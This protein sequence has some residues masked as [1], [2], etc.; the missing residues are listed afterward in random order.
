MIKSPV[1]WLLLT[2][3]AIAI[4]TA[5]GPAEATLGTNA[6]VV[7]L[8]GVWVWAALI[9]II[10][11][12]LI[13]L[14]GLITRREKLHYW[15]RALGRTGLIF[16]ITYLP[17]SLWAMQT[18]WNGLFLLEPRW[19]MAIVFAIGGLFLQIGIIL[20]KNPIWAS[21]SNF[22]YMLILWLAIQ[23]TEQVMHPP[24][25]IFNSEAILIQ[26]FFIALLCLTLIAIWLVTHMLYKFDHPYTPTSGR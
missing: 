13:G 12:G 7:Y 16:W 17:I 21:I 20:L 22:V 24:S 3:I 9:A 8:H 15:S 4:V 18:N 6:R 10:A 19:R 25:P 26:Y 1:F 11:S 14:I 5:L 23:R 2:L